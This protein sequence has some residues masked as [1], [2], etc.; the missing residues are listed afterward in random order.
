MIVTVSTTTWRVPE[1]RSNSKRSHR[2]CHFLRFHEEI[3]K[4]NVG[5]GSCQ[6]M[7][8]L[9]CLFACSFPYIEIKSHSQSHSQKCSQKIGKF[10]QIKINFV[11][12]SNSM[13]N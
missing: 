4:L 5:G 3:W 6:S 8:R 2:F 9:Q 10:C 7:C 11:E 12:G 1:V 13:V